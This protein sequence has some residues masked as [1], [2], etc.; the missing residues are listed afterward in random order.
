MLYIAEIEDW[1]ED[2]QRPLAA[3]LSLRMRTQMGFRTSTQT[4]E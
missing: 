1:A 4:F 3:Y 2:Q